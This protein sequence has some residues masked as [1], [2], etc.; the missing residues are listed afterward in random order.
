MPMTENEAARIWCDL[1]VYQWPRDFPSDLRPAWWEH[2]ERERLQ[3]WIRPFMQAIENLIGR[4][5]CLEEW[6]K[7]QIP[8]SEFENRE[9]V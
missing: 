6:R 3:E 1:N 7:G 8:L 2:A 4:E 5:K 9:R